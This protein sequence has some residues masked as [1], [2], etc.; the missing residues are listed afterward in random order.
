MTTP[1]TLPPLREVIAAL[2]LSARKAL[3]QNFILD[4][5]LTRRIARSGGALE[6]LTVIEVGAGPGGLTR[7]L[8]AEGAA[9]VIAI[10]RDNRCLPALHEIA[11]HYRDRL[12]VV[13]ADALT[14]DYAALAK[15]PTRVIANL[16]Y[17]IATE[18]LVRWLKVDP[19]P[20]W[21][22]KLI[23]MFQREVAERITAQPGTKAFGRLAVI[24]Q[25]RARPQILFTLPPRAFTPPP[26]VSS[27]VV[28][29]IPH[30]VCE[31]A[32]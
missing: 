28:E 2:G 31:P 14:L 7:A 25:W 6:K 22:D 21:Y 32:G 8:L 30:D 11:A 27:A 13:E 20:P 18:L 17:N 26:K 4:F 3:G 16:P 15:G 19:W 29:F 1:D 10:E 12:D 9:H 24:S 23:L 5:N